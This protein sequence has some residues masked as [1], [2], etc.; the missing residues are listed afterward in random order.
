MVIFGS[1]K[2]DGY[3]LFFRSCLH[4]PIASHKCGDQVCRETYTHALPI[5]LPTTLASLMSFAIPVIGDASDIRTRDSRGVGSLFRSTFDPGSFREIDCISCIL[6]AWI[7]NRKITE[8]LTISF[9]ILTALPFTGQ[10]HSTFCERAIRNSDINLRAWSFDDI[11]EIEKSMI[12]FMVLA[13]SFIRHKICH[14]FLDILIH[15]RC[16]RWL[17]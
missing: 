15:V 5:R 17:L 11:D 4:V 16:G 7:N 8:R 1:L 3:S 6:R 14:S 13:R 10:C 9:V 12:Y 2:Y